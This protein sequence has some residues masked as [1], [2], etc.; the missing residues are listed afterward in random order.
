MKIA[1]IGAGMMGSA[2]AWDLARLD[3]VDE[4]K[5]A[6][7]SQKRLD[8]I[9]AKASRTVETERIDV[10]NAPELQ[11]FLEGCDVAI[12]ALPHGAV[13]PADVIAVRMGARMVNI[14]FEDEQMALDK[15]AK[16][17]G[18]VLIP[19]C[20][21][22]PGLSNILVAEGAR[23][24]DSA[25]EGHIFVGG[26][27]QRPL[28]PLSYRLVFSVKGL[29][30]E[31]LTARVIRRGRVRSV[32][33]FE[34]IQRVHFPR[35]IGV[36]EAFLTDGLG[37]SIYTLNHL[38]ELDERTLR[39]PGHAEKI[40]FLIDAGFFESEVIETEKGKMAPVDMSSA[41][42]QKLLTRGDPRDM[43]VMRVEV[44][45]SKNGR[46]AK[47]V[48]DLVDFYDEKNGITSMGRTT[49][50]T[51]AVVAR[52]VGRREISRTGVLPPE[53]TLDERRVKQLL[54]E[55]ARK[56]VVVRRRIVRL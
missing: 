34:D 47:V 54:S 55:L 22:A 14:A 38:R 20:G 16:Q 1:V 25:V 39:W 50:F 48:F 31:Y 41:V 6:D 5:V 27:P 23:V 24:L 26:L 12:S 45:G 53:T 19:G 21:V 33:P 46:K 2:V 37:S 35:P 17:N 36:L 52:M 4:L 30:R 18:A 15:R 32:K 9:R 51:A 56:G 29:I 11:R 49:G 40:K 3:D 7:V 42:L 28:P 8:S 44:V 13:H 10:L 43:T